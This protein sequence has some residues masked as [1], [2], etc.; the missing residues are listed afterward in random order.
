MKIK[1]FVVYDS[2]VVFEDV[3]KY[4]EENKLGIMINEEVDLVPEEM[5]G[6]VRRTEEAKVPLIIVTKEYN[7][8]NSNI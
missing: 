7:Y 5:E 2:S 1:E 8:E 3:L 4:C 6:I